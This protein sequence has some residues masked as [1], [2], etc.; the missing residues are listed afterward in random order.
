MVA[1]DL[2]M[3]VGLGWVEE[4]QREVGYGM[5]DVGWMF[6]MWIIVGATAGGMAFS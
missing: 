6:S 3:G 5:W 1:V 4:G 2:R